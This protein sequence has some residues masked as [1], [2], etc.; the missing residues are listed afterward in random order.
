MRLFVG[1][2]LADAVKDAAFSA[3]D[4]LRRRIG[5]AGLRVNARWVPRDNLH[6]TLW[7]IGEVAGDR[8]SAIV[9]ALDV[10]F[11]VPPFPLVLAGPGAFPPSGVPRVFWIGVR[12][13]QDGLVAL[14]GAVG[15]RLTPLGFERERR[16]YS[17]HLTIAR[18]KDMPRR[19]EAREVRQV[20]RRATAEAGT[21]P[22]S[23]VTLFRSSVSHNGPVY[24]PLLRVPLR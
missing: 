20:L 15:E 18:V 7:F 23:G 3:A 24:E 17:A 6:I 14:N 5:D 16:P 11:D 13:G 19:A 1:V 12:S 9:G 4:A 8:A 2:E 22:V 10:P 21:S